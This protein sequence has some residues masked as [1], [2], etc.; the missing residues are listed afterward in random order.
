MAIATI[1]PA[2]GET[3]KTYEEIS[4]AEL[5]RCLAAAAGTHASYRLTD[6]DSRARWMRRAADILDEERDQ[7]AA[8][9]TTEMGK[10][11]AAAKQEVTKCGTACRYY[12][13][14]AARFLADDPADAEAVGAAQAYVSYQPIGAVLAIMPWNFPLWQAMRFAAPALMAGNVGLLKHASNVPQTALFMQDLFSRAGFPDGAF[15]TLL[16][17]SGRIE[18][19]LRDRRVAAATLT[20]SGPAGQSVASIAG[21]EIKKVVLELGGS[22]PFVV[23]PSADLPAAA[24]VAAVARCLNNGQSCIA[25]KRFIAHESIADEFERLFVAEMS[26]MTLGN[27]MKDGTDVGPL[28]SEQQRKDVEELVAD[29]VGKGAKVLCGGTAPQGPGWYYPPTVLTG[30]TPQMRVHTEE[31]FGPVATL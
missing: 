22:D 25:A 6:F 19:I 28:S 7:I 10:T 30:I 2:T 9:M 31:V 29:A 17:S 15:Q 18:G 14:N 12:A 13:D 23:M 16:V 20:G 5:E 3:L 1:N 26:A 24:K 27:P 11:L 21:S 4:A 8:M